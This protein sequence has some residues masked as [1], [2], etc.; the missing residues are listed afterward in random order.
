MPR[1]DQRMPAAQSVVASQTTTFRLPIGRRYHGLQLIGAGTAFA[2]SDLSE[3]RVLLNNKVVQRFTGAD[4]DMMNQFDGRAAAAASAAAFTLIIPFDRYGILTK[5]GEEETAVNTGSVDPNSGKSINTFSLEVD[6]GAGPTG[7]LTLDL[8]A[9]TSEQLP[10]GPGTVP[11][12]LKS[13]GDFASAAEYDVS[14]IPRGG[15]TTQF[16]DKIFLKP[17]TSTLENLR[18]L[19]NSYKVFERTAALNERLQRD[20]IRVPQ[21]GVYVIDRTEHG[22]GGDP[23]DVRG[24]D[25]WRLQFTTGAAMTV[26][27]YTHYLGGLGD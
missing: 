8:Y 12:V 5:A 21:A 6:V 10:G 27:R 14:D 23:F 7:T 22:Y 20:G 4:R 17:S 9:T 25:D 19:A 24:L 3:I 18:V 2:P 26:T 16:V 15:V 11:Y 13:V 1:V